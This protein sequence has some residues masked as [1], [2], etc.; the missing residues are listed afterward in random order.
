[1]DPMRIFDEK[2]PGL[3]RPSPQ[4]RPDG[5]SQAPGL[6]SHRSCQKRVTKFIR[7]VWR[8]KLPVILS[9][10]VRRRILG[11]F[12]N[13]AEPWT[14]STRRNYFPR[15]IIFLAAHRRRPD[16]L[17]ERVSIVTTPVGF[18]DDFERNG[19]WSLGIA[20]LAEM[21]SISSPL[22]SCPTSSCLTP[23]HSKTDFVWWVPL[24]GRSQPHIHVRFDGEGY[25]R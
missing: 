16:S 14:P 8:E 13:I 5:Y 7:H 19:E 10:L 3:N 1:M 15:S 9:W 11:G 12:Q 2:D 18:F 6:A 23:L 24:P 20:S 25:L 17:V 4:F 21:A 22:S